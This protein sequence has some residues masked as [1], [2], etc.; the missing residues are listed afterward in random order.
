[1]QSELLDLL[2][3]LGPWL[4]VAG[5]L[6]LAARSNAS[7]RQAEAE[8]TKIREGTSAKAVEQLEKWIEE[9]R[10]IVRSQAAKIRRLERE[11]NGC[12]ERYEELQRESREEILA[13][14]GRYAI[15]EADLQ[16]QIDSLERLVK[17]SDAE[18]AELDRA[19][20]AGRDEIPAP[21]RVP[22]ELRLLTQ[23]QIRERKGE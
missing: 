20:A 12:E 3:D 14:E 11:A 15:R 23:A 5:S 6:V 18:R 16:S 17:G 13:L 22:G 9:L 7:A 2:N 19:I 10:G 21:P 1:M 8:A 4:G